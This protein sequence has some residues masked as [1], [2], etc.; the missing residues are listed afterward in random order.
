M[1]GA[2]G[3][4]VV[5]RPSAKSR[6]RAVPLR[7]LCP[8][9]MR[10]I[11]RGTI[12][13]WLGLAFHSWVILIAENKAIPCTRLHAE[14]FAACRLCPKSI[15]WTGTDGGGFFTVPLTIRSA[16]AVP[17]A[18]R[19]RLKGRFPPAPT[20]SPSG[21]SGGKRERGG[22][23]QTQALGVPCQASGAKARRP[24]RPARAGMG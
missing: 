10:Q 11:P 18:S 2:G 16:R 24:T 15:L 5:D 19:P 7:R 9:T 20:G 12:S 23:H 14:A 13:E 1:R 22:P 17:S 6:R 21:A 4:F 8:R 3:R